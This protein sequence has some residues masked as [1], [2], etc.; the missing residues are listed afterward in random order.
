MS[1][2]NAERAAFAEEKIKMEEAF[3][4]VNQQGYGQEKLLEIEIKR[5]L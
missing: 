5:R 4:R 2:L 3:K 1:L